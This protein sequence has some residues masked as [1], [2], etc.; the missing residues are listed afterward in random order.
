MFYRFI[1]HTAEEPFNDEKGY[2]YKNDN[3]K[4]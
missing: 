1:E 4:T 3:L 2:L